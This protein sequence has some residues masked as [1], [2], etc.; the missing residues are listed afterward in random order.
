MRKY[1]ITS[2]G[3]FFINSPIILDIIYKA[4]RKGNF[5]YYHAGSEYNFKIP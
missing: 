1:P 4:I 3:G 2:L 5:D